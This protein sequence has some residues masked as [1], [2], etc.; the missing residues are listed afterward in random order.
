[1]SLKKKKKCCV[2][3]LRLEYDFDNRFKRFSLLN[4]LID[5]AQDV[6]GEETRKLLDL[7]EQGFHEQ[8]S[9]AWVWRLVTPTL[10][11]VAERI[12]RELELCGR[13]QEF[14]NVFLDEL[15]AKVVT[16]YA[17]KRQMSPE[18]GLAADQEAD[19]RKRRDEDDEGKEEGGGVYD[20][21]NEVA[22]IKLEEQELA[23]REK[24]A[25]RWMGRQVNV[26]L[27]GFFSMWLVACSAP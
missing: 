3:W 8:T 25:E 10:M 1:M 20:F 24:A 17:Y 12:L 26:V 22:D 27:S 23:G 15:R 21:E 7:K 5:E 14:D 16:K 11:S 18:E 4:K 9:C 19:N 13:E 6:F 2:Q